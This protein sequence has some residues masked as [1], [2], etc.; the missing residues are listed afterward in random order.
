MGA[1]VDGVRRT[2][3]TLIVS[4]LTSPNFA[5]ICDVSVE[6]AAFSVVVV[7][8]YMPW[9]VW[10]VPPAEADTSKSIVMT[11]TVL[12]SLRRRRLEFAQPSTE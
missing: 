3:A 8:S 9:V 12:M 10:K 1:T 4:M 7:V 11:A 5:A 2:S 6:I